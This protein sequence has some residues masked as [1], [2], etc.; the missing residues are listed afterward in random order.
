[1]EV[2]CILGGI[3]SVKRKFPHLVPS[4]KIRRKT[5]LN[6]DN[7]GKSHYKTEK[8][9]NSNTNIR[10]K[11]SMK[12]NSTQS[13]ESSISRSGSSSS[14][15]PAVRSRPC[16]VQQ[17]KNDQSYIMSNDQTSPLS[18]Y[19]DEVT[20]RCFLYVYACKSLY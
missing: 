18:Q 6:G 3:N 11:S 8:Y 17:E 9:N 1:M 19:K 10:I 12:N 2:S 20:N 4:R 15:I 5:N 14:T 16:S 7:D 13:K